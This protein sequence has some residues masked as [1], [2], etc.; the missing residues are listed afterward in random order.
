MAGL[1]VGLVL[2]A[3]ATAGAEFMDDRVYREEDFKKL[4]A[5]EVM[6][7]IP[8][9]P[10]PE[11]E[12]RGRRRLVLESILA[13]ALSLITVAGVAFSFLRG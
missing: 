13:G 11:E 3:G 6:A 12:S 7:E 5:V 1:F 2:G 9:L 8:P 4:L 10:T